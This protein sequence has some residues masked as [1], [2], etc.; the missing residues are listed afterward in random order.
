MT[1]PKNEP[2]LL[3]DEEIAVAKREA[4]RLAKTFKAHPEF[5]KEKFLLEAQREKDIKWYEELVNE[6]P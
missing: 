1:N 3:S 4:E 2:P 6:M 5:E